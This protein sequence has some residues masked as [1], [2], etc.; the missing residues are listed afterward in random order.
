LCDQE[1]CQC[2]NLDLDEILSDPITHLIM[3]A[4]RVHPEELRAL[5]HTL[6][7]VIFRSNPNRRFP[8]GNA[9]RDADG[10]A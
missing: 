4:D 2:R 8:S 7:G 6:A 1:F 10:N 9:A 5:C 3:V